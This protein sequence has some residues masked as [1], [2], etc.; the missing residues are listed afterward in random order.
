METKTKALFNKDFTLVVIGQIIS[1]F[2]NAILR[3][4]LPLY[5]LRATNSAFIFSTVFS[6]SFIPLC[7]FALIGGILADRLNKRNIMVMLDFF[8]AILILAFLLFFKSVSI[9]PVFTITL[10]I[11]FGIQGLYQPTVQASIPLLVDYNDILSANA[12]INQINTFA[13]LLGP[14]IGGIL[15]SYFGIT[16]ILIISI[17]CFA[18]SSFMEIFIKIEFIKQERNDGVLVT[19][20]NDLKESYL[21]AK[22]EKPI[23]FKIGF[24]VALFNMVLTTMLIVGIPIIIIQILK[25]DDLKLGLAQ[26]ILAMG[27]ILGGISSATILKNLEFKKSHIFL[28]ICSLG[29]TLMGVAMYLNISNMVTYIIINISSFILM[30]MATIFT[31]QT[32]T[33]FQ[34]QTPQNLIGKIMAI[35]IAIAVSSQPIGQIIYGLI[36]DYFIKN[37]LVDSVYIILIISSILGVLTSLYCKKNLKNI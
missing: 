6:I 23:F 35:L 32:F 25:M 15:F 17:I 28:F 24:I 37:N 19:A 4:A 8:T 22:K 16:P 26:G 36:F 34:I 3:F 20:K 21:Y 33:F 18:L 14:I 1:L 11:L 27:S 29:V 2:G 5:L 30:S 10:M 13:N 12:I 31:I 7:I 9:V